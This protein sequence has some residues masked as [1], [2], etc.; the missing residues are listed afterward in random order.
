MYS[1]TCVGDEVTERTTPSVVRR[2]CAGSN[3]GHGRHHSLVRQ[4]SSRRDSLPSYNQTWQKP[5]MGVQI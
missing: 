1:I 3:P 4:L 5:T 2:T